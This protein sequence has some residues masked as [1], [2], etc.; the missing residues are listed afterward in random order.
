MALTTGVILAD[1]GVPDIG[2]GA[3]GDHYRNT[4]NQDFYAKDG[5][6]WALIGNLDAGAADG[7]GTT[8]LSGSGVP[9][10]GDG[11]DGNYYRNT[12]N[13]DVYLKASGLWNLIGNIAGNGAD[14]VGSILLAGSGEPDNGDGAD[15]N[16][17]LNR[18]NGNFYEKASG[19]WTLRGSLLLPTPGPGQTIGS[20]EGVPNN[21]TGEDGDYC[22][23]V[24]TQDIYFKTAGVWAKIGSW[25]DVEIPTTSVFMSG[26][27]APSDLVGEDGN[28]YRDTE[29][30]D[31]YQKGLGTWT[32]IGSWAAGGGGGAG[33]FVVDNWDMTGAPI[34]AVP[35]T[36]VS[37]TIG[38][39]TPNFTLTPVSPLELGSTYSAAAAFSAGGVAASGTGQSWMRF[40]QP[41]YDGGDNV[42]GILTALVNETATI[43]DIM[44]RFNGGSPVG[45]LVGAYAMTFAA[46]GDAVFGDFL[47]SPGMGSANL[48]AVAGDDIYFGFDYDTGEILLQRETDAAIVSGVPADLSALPVGEKL[49]VV[50][51]VLATSDTI[52]FLAGSI[53]ADFSTTDA[54]KT[55]FAAAGNPVIP[56][57]AEDGKV[58][59]VITSGGTF[60][61]STAQVGD[62]VQFYDNESKIIITRVVPDST[63]AVAAVAEDLG[64]LSTRVTNAEG[65]ILA[66][67]SQGSNHEG[68]IVSLESA[69]AAEKTWAALEV[70]N[71]VVP[72]GH[73]STPYNLTVPAATAGA[74]R[75]L[76]VDEPLAL[77]QLSISSGAKAHFYL[78]FAQ[79]DTI[80]GTDRIVFN[81]NQYPIVIPVSSFDQT[82]YECLFDPNLNAWKITAIPL[83]A[84]VVTHV[85]VNGGSV[86]IASR[87]D[88]TDVTVVDT[89]GSGT[90]AAYNATIPDPRNY[91]N[92]I[93]IEIAGGGGDEV[94]ALTLTAG[95]SGVSNNIGLA[96]AG[97][98]FLATMRKTSASWA[99]DV[100]KL[101]LL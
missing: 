75:V 84:H 2:I 100:V 41:T 36:G 89:T 85:A 42:F 51:L 31:I 80:L 16:F 40:V 101:N 90:I 92:G 10:N 60:G 20:G 1:S 97:D 88:S 21:A 19:L 8:W 17:Y 29:T 62:F 95:A 70:E 28:H 27:G 96:Q 47:G 81:Y 67:E 71:I 66:L 11:A 64:L 54:G 14:G 68:R 65:D 9:D 91:A 52:A 53:T 56:V 79:G 39:A 49:K 25:A 22:R 37:M 78:K 93:R 69:S 30:Q 3:D 32:L 45:T 61:G 43:A 5:G 72:S 24:L 87:D 82:I 94:T 99:L 77:I 34:A 13:Q 6:V 57:G 48:N 23:D 35:V 33:P 4:D 12:S 73:T 98:V 50:T 44:T 63:G 26:A 76:E 18:A 83:I 38:G 58:Y 15:G 59:K 7:V 46:T 86:A 74:Y 55:G